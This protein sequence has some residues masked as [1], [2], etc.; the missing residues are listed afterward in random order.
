[1]YDST[2]MNKPRA[3]KKYFDRETG[4]R[5]WT[6]GM[7]RIAISSKRKD[8]AVKNRFFEF[9]ENSPIMREVHSL[10]HYLSAR[11]VVRRDYYQKRRLEKTLTKIA[12]EVIKSLL[13]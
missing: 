2:H 1:M 12:I 9:D 13:K 7:A 11:A 10:H 8:V 3:S 5:R 6:V 4:Q